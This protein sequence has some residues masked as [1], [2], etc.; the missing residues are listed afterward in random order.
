MKLDEV[1]R[2]ANTGADAIKRAPIVSEDTGV[3]CLRIGDV[4]QKR[5]YYDWGNTKT[6]DED[7][8]KYKLEVD[9]IIIARTG[10]TIGVNC[11]IDDNVNAVYNNGL[12]RI[13]ADIEKIIPR[14]LWY[15]IR[16]LD[17]QNYI[18]SIAFGT[19]T[20]PNMKIKDFLK[21][22]FTYL[23]LPVQERI[24]SIIDSIDK[25]IK[26]NTEINDNLQAQAFALYS[27][28]IID[29][30]DDTWTLGV[31]SDIAEITMGQS[32]KGDT[33]NEDGVGTVF[34]QGRAE[35][36]FRFPTRRL[37][38]TEPKR[39]AQTNDA[40]MSVRAPVGDMN[41][42]Y[43][44]CCIG[45]G[46]A[47][48]HSKDNHQSYVLYTMF[49]LHEQLNVF[50]GEGTVFGSI[51]KDAL[52]AMPIN[53]PPTNVIDAFEEIVAPMDKAIRNNYEEICHLTNIR[54][55]LLPRLMSGEIDVAE[56][57]I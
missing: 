6:S 9:D 28:M 39:M 48:I 29:N 31:L 55:S 53:I 10:N 47:A 44:D 27:K 25:K 23:E 32:P 51:N 30:A 50:N 13:K 54:D 34:F 16:G 21:Y 11:I 7:Y 38:T 42:A 43:E 17:C 40:L 12:I 3:K 41:V 46:L 57:D 14:Y 1:V 33:Y 49:N 36:G 8:E 56:L 2:F 52:N 37:C 45:R 5:P 4:S 26:N 20:Q 15:L 18:Q 19:S 24:V 22:E 35:F